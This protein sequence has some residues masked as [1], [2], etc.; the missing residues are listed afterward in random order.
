MQYPCF[1]EFLEPQEFLIVKPNYP[2]LA[3]I[4]SLYP[5]P[6]PTITF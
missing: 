6:T 2:H 3:K 5:A 1:P 4:I